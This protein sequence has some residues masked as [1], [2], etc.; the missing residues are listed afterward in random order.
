M[1]GRVHSQK[2]SPAGKIPR[3]TAEVLI[4]VKLLLASYLIALDISEEKP[5]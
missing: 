4:R 3:A 2:N 5:E 1:M